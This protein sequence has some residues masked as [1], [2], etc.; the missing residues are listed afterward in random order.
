MTYICNSRTIFTHANIINRFNEIS[1]PSKPSPSKK[2]EVSKSSE[3]DKNINLENDLIKLCF[4]DNHDARLI[5]FEKL[6]RNYIPAAKVN[7]I[8]L[9]INDQNW[10]IYP[11]VQQLDK[12]HAG[13]WFFDDEC[14]RWRAEDPNSEAPGCGES[15]GGGPG[16]G[17]GRGGL[18]EHVP[19]QCV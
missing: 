18:S 9:M 11:N 2:E 17:V 5:I 19:S 1:K 13:Q 12:R 10:G 15:F 8:Q 16:G 4:S 14:T 7:F 3:L 6:S